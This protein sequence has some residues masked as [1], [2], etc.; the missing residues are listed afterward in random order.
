MALQFYNSIKNAKK[1]SS[2]IEENHISDFS[3]HIFGALLIC[4][5]TCA[6]D[7]KTTKNQAFYDR[8]TTTR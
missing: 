6:A 8:K 5:E 4:L 1:I 3:I 7:S 2:G